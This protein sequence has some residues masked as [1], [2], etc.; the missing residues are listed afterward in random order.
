MQP[1]SS[2]LMGLNTA[3]LLNRDL[4]DKLTV[5]GGGI[6][7]LDAR[8]C[9]LPFIWAHF[10]PHGQGE[11]DEHTVNHYR[12]VIS[13]LPRDARILGC[14]FSPP[15]IMVE[16]FLTTPSLFAKK[17]FEFSRSI[18][19]EFSEITDWEIWNEPNASGFYLS[20]RE[21]RGIRPWTANEFV[22]FVLVPGA[23]GVKAAQPEAVLC[24]AGLAEN[25]I[26]EHHDRAQPV[27]PNKLPRRKDYIPYL[28]QEPTDQV[29]SIP[30]FWSA[31]AE[32]LASQ[33][34]KIL[35]LF[36]A[37]G[38]HPSPHFLIHTRNQ[39]SLTHLTEKSTENFI[40]VLTEFGLDEL[41]VWVTEFGVRS[42]A[43]SGPHCDDEPQQA[44]FLAHSMEFFEKSSM[45]GR[46]YWYNYIDTQFD[47]MNEETFGLL[48]HRGVPRQAFFYFKKW[49]NRLHQNMENSGFIDSLARAYARDDKEIQRLYWS[50]D[51][52]NNF[53]YSRLSILASGAGEMLVYPG[54]ASGDYMTM[55]CAKKYLFRGGHHPRVDI[56]LSSYPDSG[57]FS[58][59]IDLETDSSKVLPAVVFLFEEEL[60]VGVA[61]GN[62]SVFAKL[63][64]CDFPFVDCESITG[65][66]LEWMRDHIRIEVEVAEICIHRTIDIERI[67]GEFRIIP[68]IRIQ[69]LAEKPVVA[70]FTGF[71]MEIL[72]VASRLSQPPRN[73]KEEEDIWFLSLPRYS[74]IYQDDW[75]LRMLRFKGDGFFV[76]IGGHNGVENS[77]TILLE[78]IFGWNGMIVEA[79]PRW[80]RAICRNRNVPAFNNAAFSRSGERLK[81]VDAGA[82]GGLV[83]YLQADVHS[84][85]RQS[86][87][88]AGKVIDVL[89]LRTDELLLAGACP[90]IVDYI[91]IDT[92]GSEYEVLKGLDFTRWKFALMTIEHGGNEE[93]R[94]KVWSILQEVGYTRHRVWFE[95]WFWHPEYLAL[96]LGVSQSEATEHAKDVFRSERHHRR[97]RLMQ[98]AGQ[99]QNSPSATDVLFEA[100]KVFHPNNVHSICEL[101]R[102]LADDGDFD[103]AHQILLEGKLHFPNDSTLKAASHTLLGRSDSTLAGC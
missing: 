8:S 54:R 51:S 48:D 103:L 30:N 15:Q 6:R 43:V 62:M 7:E 98:C 22:E 53:G 33:K 34:P 96:A 52:N 36:R 11:L 12:K 83:D 32:V 72:P 38:L 50:V 4:S 29:Y 37:C 101:I 85:T 61:T 58:L 79:N 67:D 57:P 28:G 73:Q 2:L 55:T 89:G 90:E 3:C 20:V 84:P 44:A 24:I 78:R 69:R 17:M 93:S 25:G 87:M 86:V 74:Q 92:E 82:I 94:R 66:R 59:R 100:A 27:L 75:I 88:D 81:F 56:A 31:L 95:D 99:L 65:I 68:R 97:V 18:S 76:E 10:D 9:R 16:T 42:L 23:R 91:S 21:E 47:L 71:Q 41:D 49:A 102:N 80:H 39:E 19:E 63:K 35:N 26:L 77:N 70:S 46:V 5:L 14:I 13:F 64:S 1:S 60:K 45:I 40:R